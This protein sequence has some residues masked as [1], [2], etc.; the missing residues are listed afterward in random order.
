MR[1]SR[2]EKKVGAKMHEGR[3]SAYIEFYGHH[4]PSLAGVQITQ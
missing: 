2:G 4:L 3:M 1:V